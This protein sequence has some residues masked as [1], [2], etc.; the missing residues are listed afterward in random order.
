MTERDLP[1]LVR[2]DGAVVILDFNRP[3]A[4]NAIDV[5]MAHAFLAAV[6]S[7]SANRSVRAVLL[8]G[9]GK[10]FMAGGFLAVLRS[11]PSAEAAALIG[12][13]HEA[14]ALLERLN[15]PVVAQVH[16]EAAGAGLS[17]TLQADFVNAA[18]GTRFNLA[19]VNIGT[20]CDAGASWALPRWVGLRRALELA[21]LG[22]TVE[23]AHAERISL[24]SRAAGPTGS[25]NGRVPELFEQY[26]LPDRPGCLLCQEATFL[27]W[28][29]TVALLQNVPRCARCLPAPPA[30]RREA[31]RGTGRFH[32]Q[33]VA[34]HAGATG[35][36]GRFREQ[37]TTA[38]RAP[39]RSLTARSN[40][41]LDRPR[42]A[43]DPH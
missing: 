6:R 18:E 17:L 14:L 21:L 37:M 22:D 30:G 23:A 12:P 31:A 40:G 16:G 24:V 9:E 36:P 15:A 3:G 35:R 4:L 39:R 43:T 20:S 28:A 26:R 27:R 8:R 2:R 13:L 41:H 19:Y 7:I 34:W 29:L 5:P 10:G 33:R 1:L 25:R 38:G 32:V 11:D 42:R